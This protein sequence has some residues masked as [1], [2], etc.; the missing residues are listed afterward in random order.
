MKKRFS[1]ILAA[2]LIS[3]LFC[4][5]TNTDE[6]SNVTPSADN[7]PSVAPSTEITPDKSPENSGVLGEIEDDM[8]NMGDDIENGIDNAIDDV[9][10]PK[11][12]EDT[13]KNDSSKQ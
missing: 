6:N 13:D 10:S 9:T 2:A 1:I 4:G 7:T 8:E 3:M 11:P 12:S 5:C